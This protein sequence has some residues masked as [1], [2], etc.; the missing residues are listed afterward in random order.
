MGNILTA[1]SS[2][3]HIDKVDDFINVSVHGNIK[4]A[5]K[6][7]EGIDNNNVEGVEKNVDVTVEEKV[8]ENAD[9]NV[10]VEESIEEHAYW[11]EVDISVEQNK[12]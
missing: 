2:K 9:V 6:V 4:V 10:Q 3:K 11:K 8:D 7:E 5:V 12:L 1:C